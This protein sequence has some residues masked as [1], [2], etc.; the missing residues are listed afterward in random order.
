MKSTRELVDALISQIHTTT[1][2]KEVSD[3]LE[4]M[5]QDRNF[6]LHANAIVSDDSLTQPQQKRQLTH[7]IQVVE[8]PTLKLFFEE[9]LSKRQF[10]LF[11]TGK[12]DYFDN[13]TRQFQVATEELEMVYLV[14]AVPL[15]PPTLETIATDLSGSFGYKVV[16]KHEVD[17][18]ILGGVQMRIENLVFDLSVRTKF[19]QFQRA[20][21]ASLAKT[22]K[23]INRHQA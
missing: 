10:W 17:K 20:W 8:E 12:M 13:F 23:L 3:I 16:L 22:D 1:V 6:K 5:S 11:S 7:L 15:A 4:E 9:V 21:I 19:N 18:Q 2:L 14:T